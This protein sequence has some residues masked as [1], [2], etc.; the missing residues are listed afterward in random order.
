MS[1]LYIDRSRSIIQDESSAWNSNNSSAYRESALGF[2]P[3]RRRRSEFRVECVF[4]QAGLL[5]RILMPMNPSLGGGQFKMAKLNPTDYAN[6]QIKNLFYIHFVFEPHCMMIQS[7]MKGQSMYTCVRVPKNR[8]Q[9]YSITTMNEEEYGK[10]IDIAVPLQTLLV[11]L[12]MFAQNQELSLVYDSDDR[13]ILMNGRC[14]SYSEYK[15]NGDVGQQ[16]VCRVNT[17]NM[18]PLQL[19]FDGSHFNFVDVDYFS[20][21]PRLLYPCLYDIASDSTSNKLVLELLPLNDGNNKCVLG[22]ASGQSSIA[23]EW[24]FSY[25]LNV[26]DEYNVSTKHL[27]SYSMRCWMSVAN[28]IKLAQRIRIAVKGDGVLLIQVSMMD[29]ASDGI[30][31]YYQM[32]PL[33]H[34]V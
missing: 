6:N 32:Y 5:K 2:D 14:A 3:E 27:H 13:Q 16:M 20:I 12:N 26:F 29:P 4:P 22:L 1:Q 24:D 15:Y 30:H 8:L 28:G 25:D 7:M 10:I 34:T 18:S 33:L 11:C 9:K 23:I 21:S 17:L 31:F 19:P